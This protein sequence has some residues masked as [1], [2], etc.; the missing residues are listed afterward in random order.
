[1]MRG[2]DVSGDWSG[3]GTERHE[4][5]ARAVGRA[6]R[7]GHDEHPTRRQVAEVTKLVAQSAKRAGKGAVRSGHWFAEVTL[8]AA[9]HLPARDLETLRAHHDGLAGALLARLLIRNA[10]LASG[11]VGASTG[12]LAAVSTA[13]ATWITLPVELAAE[14]LIV[15]AVE[16][17]LVAELHEAAGYGVAKDIRTNGPLIARAWTETRGLNTT[18]LAGLALPGQPGAIAA[19]ASDLLGRSARDQLTM[20][21]RRRLMKRAGRNTAT[22]APLMAGAIAGGVLNR[23]ATRRLGLTVARTLGIPPP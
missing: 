8:D 10:S 23:R 14:T 2:V 5:L 12:A 21:I 15:V 11:T 16:M 20:Q 1:M 18:E 6:A 17:K 4:E 7:G 13:T 3:A 19:A 22:L 9:S